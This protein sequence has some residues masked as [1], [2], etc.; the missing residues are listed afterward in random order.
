MDRS[1]RVGGTKEI[2]LNPLA[3]LNRQSSTQLVIEKKATPQTV[4]NGSKIYVYTLQPFRFF[5]T[6]QDSRQYTMT[7]L[8]HMV[9]SDNFLD[10][11]DEKSAAALQQVNSANKNAF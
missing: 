4:S 8:K 11:P 6:N 10:L 1:I 5:P 7:S 9:G 3:D 2:A